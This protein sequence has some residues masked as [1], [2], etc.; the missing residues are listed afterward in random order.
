[1]VADEPD[2]ER[3]FQL[4]PNTYVGGT[5]KLL[6]FPEIIRRFEVA[7]I[8]SHSDSCNVRTY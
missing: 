8:Y 5:D 2:M 6:P 1:M 3:L 7:T 4:P